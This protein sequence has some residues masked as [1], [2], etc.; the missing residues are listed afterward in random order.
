[1][2]ER[3]RDSMI[4]YLRHRMDEF[5]ITPD[6][7]ASA[8][9]CEQQTEARYGNA[10]GDTWSGEGEI[11]QWLKQAVSAGQSIQHFELSS[12]VAAPQKNREAVDWRNDPF[13]GSPLAR[14][15]NHSR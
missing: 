15:E 5:G 7:L 9:A 2:D 1:M 4:A 11:P 14:Q 13:A 10:T 3:K 6:D 8:L 12:I